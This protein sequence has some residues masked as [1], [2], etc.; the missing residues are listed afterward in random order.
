MT[1]LNPDDEFESVLIHMVETR[2]SKGHDYGD[3][4]DTFSNITAA[5]EF[6]VEPW[7]GAAI[8]LND[9]VSRVKSMAKKRNLKNESVEDS[10]LDIAIYGIIC[11]IMYRRDNNGND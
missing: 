6:G 8:R 11:L 7:L 3:D 4:A 9:K 2:R 1:T 10:F 5:T